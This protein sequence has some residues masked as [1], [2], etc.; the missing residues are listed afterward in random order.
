M[1]AITE[2]VVLNTKVFIEVYYKN[3]AFPLKDRWN[4]F[5]SA[6][7][8]TKN[9]E[10]YVHHFP[11]QFESI[12]DKYVSDLE[13]HRVMHLNDFVEWVEECEDFP[14]LIDE[15][16]EYVLSINLGSFCYDW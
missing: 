11:S 1:L 8:D 3:K 10:S 13:R 4:V 15:L 6:P 5:C 16:K 9:H 14:E 7:H 12:V 2:R